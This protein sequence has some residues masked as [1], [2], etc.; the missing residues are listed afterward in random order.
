MSIFRLLLPLFL[1]SFTLFSACNSG[2]AFDRLT[3]G[4]LEAMAES[5]SELP[6][7]DGDSP[8]DGDESP[9]GDMET[10]DEFVQTCEEGDHSCADES[11]LLVCNEWGEWVYSETCESGYKC[12]VGSCREIGTVDGDE[13][14]DFDRETDS[15][16]AW[17]CSSHFDCPFG[18]ACDPTHSDADDTG[19]VYAS[20]CEKDTDCDP[21]WLCEDAANWKECF[22]GEDECRV[23]GD[24][25]YGYGCFMGDVG[26]MVCLEANECE[27]DAD[28]GGEMICVQGE[29][30]NVCQYDGDPCQSH[31]DCEFGYRCNTNL[32]Y[33]VCEYA[34]ECVT[35]ADCSAINVCATVE[36]WKECRL[37]TSP[38]FCQSD[39]DCP[40][41]FYCET[42]IAG[43]GTCRSL[44]ECFSD[45]ECP[46]YFECISNG[47]YLECV[48]TVPC[49]RHEDC[50]FGYRCVVAQP[51]NV[52][53]YANECAT[54]ADC[55]NFEECQP[56]GNWT[57]CNY[58][59]P[60]MCSSD[61]DCQRDEYCDFILG[62]IGNC[63]SRNQCY[64]DE[65]CGD[66]LICE[67]NGEFNECVP[68]QQQSCWFDFQCQDG[69]QCADGVCKPIYAGMC[70][71][72]EGEWT[73]W[74]SDCLM[75][76]MGQA[77]EFIP[78]DGCNGSVRSQSLS[79]SIGSFEETSTSNYNL[80]L[81]FISQCSAT[82]NLATVMSVTCNSCTAQLGR[83]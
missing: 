56:D 40:E 41:G 68:A 3:D 11:V 26:L 73:V 13:D 83:L 24:C 64:A 74:M 19:C 31:E 30:W 37:N 48:E 52:C 5:D 75:L 47:D 45:D 65:D 36:N 51:R 9:D 25:D 10:D 66:G 44:N 28:C 50:G 81:G 14:G 46:E 59:F 32:A 77:Y 69:W 57:V 82:V 23:H 67:N 72:I 33:P 76:T 12:R 53:E 62:P 71:D 35:D 80:T 8:S 78:E 49:Q 17:Q 4:D 16:F 21:G 70:T 60:S 43:Y 79:I 18:F 20:N 6:A 29:Y 7:V 1:L 22:P 27:V 55:G 39:N 61:N 15:E 54:D 42:V 34:S 38:D 63:V 2:V 58:S